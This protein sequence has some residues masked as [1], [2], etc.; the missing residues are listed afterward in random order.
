VIMIRLN[1]REVPELGGG[2]GF[3]SPDFSQVVAS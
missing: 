1:D 3:I 2:A